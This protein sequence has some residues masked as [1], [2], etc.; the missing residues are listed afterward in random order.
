MSLSPFQLLAETSAKELDKQNERKEYVRDY[1]RER[2]AKQKRKVEAEEQER[3]QS[4]RKTIQSWQYSE[5]YI[6]ESMVDEVF[7]LQNCYDF[8]AIGRLINER[9]T[10]HYV[11]TIKEGDPSKTALTSII[12]H[13][14]QGKNPVSF[15]SVSVE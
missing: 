5:K 7:R 12:S 8:E 9:V 13:Q 4:Q 6:I 15:Q 3:H 14:G 2:R 1:N 11:P 10:V